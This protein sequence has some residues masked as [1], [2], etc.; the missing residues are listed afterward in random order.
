MNEATAP[1]SA[2]VH[3]PACRGYIYTIPKAGTYLMSAY[4]EAIGNVSTGWHLNIDSYLNTHAHSAEVNTQYP[5]RTSVDRGYIETLRHVPPRQ[6]VFGHFNPQYIPTPMV[7]RRDFRIV[8]VH[9]H[10]RDVLVSSFIDMRYRRKDVDLLSIA[11]IPDVHAAFMTF[12]REHGPVILSICWNYLMLRHTTAG[13][14]YRRLM[15]STRTL[16]VEFES[17]IHP[18]SGPVVAR[19][20]AALMSVERSDD[21]I[22]QCWQR[23][24][25]A[26]N[27]TKAT[28][29]ALDFDRE[30]LW[31]GAAA[32]W[33][34]AHRF[35]DVAAELG[36]R[37]ARR[38]SI[39]AP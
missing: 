29:I 14:H 7:K 37:T 5:S 9:R 39:D 2:P 10:P 4:L 27:K 28:N 1:S 24:L 38:S 34:H 13:P 20:I 18:I 15:G 3:A 12:L 19:D 11:R 8:A 32:D 31:N 21:D 25:Q 16:F 22:R 30:T 33:Y 17:F 6:H 35:D 23:A 26:E 36:Y